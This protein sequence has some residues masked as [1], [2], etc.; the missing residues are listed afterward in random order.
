MLQEETVQRKALIRHVVNPVYADA[1]PPPEEALVARDLCAEEEDADAHLHH[2][3]HEGRQNR[4]EP[5]VRHAEEVG[6]DAAGDGPHEHEDPEARQQGAGQACG[7]HLRRPWQ[8][9]GAHAVGGEHVVVDPHRGHRRCHEQEGNGVGDLIDQVHVAAHAEGL[10]FWLLARHGRPA[11][12]QDANHAHPR[13][14]V[15]LLLR[16]PQCAARVFRVVQHEGVAAEVGKR[17][18]DPVGQHDL[19]AAQETLPADKCERGLARVQ[20]R[21]RDGVVVNGLGVVQEGPLARE[22]GKLAE[23]RPLDRAAGPPVLRT[24]VPFTDGQGGLAAAVALLGLLQVAAQLAAVWREAE[25]LVQDAGRIQHHVQLL[26]VALGPAL[27]L[28]EGA[29]HALAA[30]ACGQGHG[31]AANVRGLPAEAV[32]LL[33]GDGVLG[34]AAVN[35]AGRVLQGGHEEG[36]VRAPEVHQAE[37]VQRGGQDAKE[38]LA[39]LV[40]RVVRAPDVCDVPEVLRAGHVGGAPVGAPGAIVVLKHG[41]EKHLQHVRSRG[42]V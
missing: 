20:D 31:R 25:R 4:A 28:V 23:H 37:A 26:D 7:G 18:D 9:I 2:R 11:A 40:H 41:R 32:Q 29:C 6:E 15:E 10:P 12:L 16:A 17:V 34:H 39:R 35:E 8:H 24:R 30:K 5:V 36:H 27:A 42:H 1:G 21:Q 14:A 19:E 33:A 22:V 13:V 3:S 38:E